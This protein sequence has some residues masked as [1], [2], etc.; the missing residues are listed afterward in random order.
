M[1]PV[2]RCVG[3]GVGVALWGAVGVEVG[4]SAVGTGEVFGPDPWPDGSDPQFEVF[5]AIVGPL[6]V[7]V[8]D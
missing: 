2:G 1:R 8:V 7:D 3:F 6:A 5:G 4:F